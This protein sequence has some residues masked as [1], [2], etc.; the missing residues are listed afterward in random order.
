MGSTY[1]LPVITGIFGVSFGIC[2]FR[3][4]LSCEDDSL[5]R[6]LQIKKCQRGIYPPSDFSHLA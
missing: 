1:N 3:R 5:D 4:G 6:R 2:G